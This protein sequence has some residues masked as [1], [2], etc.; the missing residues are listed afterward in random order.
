[1]RYYLLVMAGDIEP[2]LRGPF[3]SEIEVD[4]AALAHR[5]ADPDK[6]DGL[7]PVT[8]A[9]DGE[10]NIEAYSGGYLDDGEEEEELRPAV[11][12]QGG[13]P[14]HDK[15]RQLCPEQCELCGGREWNATSA[16][17]E[18]RYGCRRC[19]HFEVRHG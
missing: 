15:L 12:T 11:R 7:Y 14:S 2:E 3:E 19:G 16:A 6:D 4:E 9:D 18:L 5:K 1:M 17:G 13:R 8:V 10:L